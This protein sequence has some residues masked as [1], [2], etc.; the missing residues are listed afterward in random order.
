MS[1]HKLAHHVKS[2]GRGEDTMLVHM[3]PGEVHGLQALAM[4]HGGSLT[5]NPHTGLPEAGFLSSLLPTILGVGLTVASGG[6]LSPLMAAGLVGGGTAIA[7]GSLQKGLMAGLGAYGGAGLGAGLAEAGAAAL[8]GAAAGETAANLGTQAF[9]LAGEAATTGATTLGGTAT[10]AAQQATQKAIES[11]GMTGFQGYNGLPAQ[12]AMYNPQVAEAQFAQTQAAQQAA[13]Q[14][15]AAQ[16]AAA[17]QATANPFG[18]GANVNYG[19]DQIAANAPA[20]NIDQ[21]MGPNSSAS[22]YDKMKAGFNDVTSSGPKAWNFIKQNPGTFAGL[23]LTAMQAMTPEAKAAKQNQGMIRPYTLSRTQNPDAYAQGE[24]NGMT[25][26]PVYGQPFD[27]SERTYFNDVY[28]AGTPYKAP[29]P[30]YKA[31]GGLTGLA[32]GGTTPMAPRNPVEQMSN[33]NAIGANSGY[34]MAN[35]QSAAYAIPTNRPISQNVLGSTGDIAVDP[36]TGEEKFANGGGI[37]HLGGYSDGGRLLRGPG[38]GVS[39][40]IPAQI[41]DKQPARLADGEF[42]VPARIVSELGNGST[43]AGAKQLYAMMDRVQKARGK[44]TGKDKVAVNSKAARFLP[45]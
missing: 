1:L 29:G 36:Y 18:A 7:T 40:D 26:T 33:Q 35:I 25:R 19:A 32:A 24:I 34:P 42:V 5:V 15:A 27:S 20:N 38:D 16:Q 9:P 43:E 45:A 12:S 14:Q 22:Y 30:E 11:G 4:K 31:T 28:T 2:A 21:I 13:A 6:A 41:G 3:T 39:D 8:P 37:S 23:G 10:T 44:T 17:Q